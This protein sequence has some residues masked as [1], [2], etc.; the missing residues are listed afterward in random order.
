MK[1]NAL[2]HPPNVAR[3]TFP[4][5]A[6]NPY[7]FAQLNSAAKKMLA[8]EDGTIKLSFESSGKDL[9]MQIDNKA[10][11]EFKKSQVSNKNFVFAI[12]EFFGAKKTIHLLI[13]PIHEGR[14]PLV[15]VEKIGPNNYK[16]V[17]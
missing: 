17:L 10:G 3:S 4:A 1:F 2:T 9:F 6:F 16:K 8:I 5:I 15:R 13:E 12:L 7:G 11:F 14:H